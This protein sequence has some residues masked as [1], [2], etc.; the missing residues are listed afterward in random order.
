MWC[1]VRDSTSAYTSLS[2]TCF[3]Y[4]FSEFRVLLGRWVPPEIVV[5]CPST[6]GGASS[7]GYGV[8]G[9]GAS[10]AT[11]A[12]ASRAGSAGNDVPGA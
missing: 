6:R 11:P 7:G 9:P 8:P 12:E 5:M 3:R 1:C 4:L 10:N 2:S